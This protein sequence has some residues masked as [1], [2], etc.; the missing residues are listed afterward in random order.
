MPAADPPPHIGIF[1]SGVGGLSVL[2]ALRAELPGV[3]CTYVADTRHAPYGEKPPQFIRERSLAIGA[4]LHRRGTTL[5]VVACNT[6]TALA[7]DA[8]RAR[9]PQW[10]IVGVEPGIKPAL[11]LSRSGRVAVMAT[12]ATLASPRFLRLLRAHAGE[13]D[14]RLQPCPGLAAAIERDDPQDAELLA[15]LGQHAQQLTA[16]AVDTVVLGCT[17]YPFV[18]EALQA[19]LPAGVI[20]VDTAEAVARRVADL[21]GPQPAPQRA[22]APLLLST[23]DLQPLQRLARHWL[24]L[25]APAGLLRL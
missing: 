21:I 1:D 20:L 4:E 22:V 15:L 11:A 2:R 14:V 17:H 12:P 13:A 6:A 3:A 10:P 24:G 18:A 25:A 23:G 5:L 7:V 8:L 9:W 16:A 19:R